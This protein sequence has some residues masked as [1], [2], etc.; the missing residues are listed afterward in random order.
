MVLK[1]EEE[2]FIIE[3]P[4]PFRENM[5]ISHLTN[6][7]FQYLLSSGR[8]DLCSLF[9]KSRLV[10]WKLLFYGVYMECIGYIHTYV[11]MSVCMHVCI[12]IYTNNP[13]G[14]FKL[15]LLNFVG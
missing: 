3:T 6:G 11:C 12:C 1:F 4:I 8:E 15:S 5:Q 13:N 9:A 2:F 10:K 7:T 14:L